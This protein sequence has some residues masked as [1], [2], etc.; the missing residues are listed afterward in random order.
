MLLGWAGWNQSSACDTQLALMSHQPELEV[1]ETS[2]GG[3]EEEKICDQKKPGSII[4][5][6]L[7][8]TGSPLSH[9]RIVWL[10]PPK[11]TLLD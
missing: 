6:T 3:S 9:S 4:G 5:L 8:E 1:G 10:T 11:P 2:S 7:P